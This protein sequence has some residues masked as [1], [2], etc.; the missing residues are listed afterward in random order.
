MKDDMPKAESWVA[1]IFGRQRSDELFSSLRR[2]IEQAF[3]D[4][5][6]MM[7]GAAAPLAP[8]LDVAETA[9]A[10]VISAELPGVE[11]AEVDVSLA[12]DLLTIKGEKKLE[13]EDEIRH[14]SERFYGAFQRTISVP[15]GVDPDG[16]TAVMK[17]G[18]LTITLPKPAEMKA[19]ARKIAVKGA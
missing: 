12:E 10:F 5:P 8:R 6:R 14:R 19:T 16:V 17:N 9:E 11:M 3:Q 1:D 4:F 18:V 15:K 13:R 2:E 7:S